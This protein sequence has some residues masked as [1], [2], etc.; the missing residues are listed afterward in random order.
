[1]QAKCWKQSSIRLLNLPIDPVSFKG[2]INRVSSIDMLCCQAPQKM[3]W[4]IHMYP[5]PRFPRVEWP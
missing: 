1:M 4:F 3:S 2:K 5:L